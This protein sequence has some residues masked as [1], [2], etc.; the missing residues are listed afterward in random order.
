[1][2]D[3]PGVRSFGLG[4]VDPDELLD[5][6]ADLAALA[7]SCP[8]GCTHLEDAS[9][10]ALDALVAE[11]KA[12]ERRGRPRLVSYRRLAVTLRKNDPWAL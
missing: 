12:G 9:D 7:E 1:M 3:T 2:I 11:G 5:A 4:H 10:C 6:F 8:R